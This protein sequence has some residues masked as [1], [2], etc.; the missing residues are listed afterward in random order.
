MQGLRL[1]KSSGKLKVSEADL[2]SACETLL[3]YDGWRIFRLEQNYSEK[4]RK[5]VGERGAPDG[6]YIRYTPKKVEWHAEQIA[7]EDSWKP[8]APV[9]AEVLWC[10]WKSPTGKPSNAQRAWIA[11]E[12]ARGAL[13]LLAG[14]DFPATKDGWL[15]WY[16]ASGLRRKI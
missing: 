3:K 16:R 2:Q 5:S 8:M 15:A 12:T 4:K 1:D 13:V 9:Q 14:A 6:L 11:Q 10:E 7:Y